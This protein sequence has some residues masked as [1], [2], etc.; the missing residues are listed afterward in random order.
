MKVIEYD[1]KVGTCEQYDSEKEYL[2]MVQNTI[3]I[4]NEDLAECDK[5]AQVNTFEEAKEYR[6][7]ED[8]LI[9]LRE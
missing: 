5:I 3:S 1:N 9:T 2:L 8:Y 7:V 4:L 6:Q